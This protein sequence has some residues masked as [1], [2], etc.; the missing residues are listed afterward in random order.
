MDN[1]LEQELNQVRSFSSCGE[2]FSHI[3][4]LVKKLGFECCA[5]GL[6]NAYPLSSQRTEILTTYPTEWQIR[7]HKE[8][9]INIDPTVQHALKSHLPLI[10][11]PELACEREG[12]WEEACSFGL[13]FGWV[14]SIRHPNGALGILSFARPHDRVTEVEIQR[15]K[16]Q[17]LWLTNMAHFTL[18]NCLNSERGAGPALT[19]REREILKWTADGKTSDEIGLILGIS[20]R[21]VNFH[22]GQCVSKLS[23]ANKTAATVKAALM[24]LLH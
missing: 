18:S 10:W 19:S 5:F 6:T 4:S 15:M 9:L 3:V 7:Y 21:T 17:L 1:W 22:I 16:Q 23:V 14:H 20:S 8:N 24:G 2:Y 11:G 12:F 13:E